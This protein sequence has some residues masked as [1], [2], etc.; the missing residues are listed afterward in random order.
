MG[1]LRIRL[2]ELLPGPRANGQFVQTALVF[3][4]AQQDVSD[5]VELDQ[6]ACVKGERW[7]RCLPLARDRYGFV[8]VV[9]GFFQ[10]VVFPELRRRLLDR[11]ASVPAWFLHQQFVHLPP[12]ATVDEFK[13]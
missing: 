2:L 13:R 4:D 5:E 12:A 10:R 3:F 6:R 11:A 9:D 8:D 7:T 1:K